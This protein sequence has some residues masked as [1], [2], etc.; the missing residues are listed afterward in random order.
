[1]KM[2]PKIKLPA[3]ED[4]GRSSSN[5]VAT[6]NSHHPLGEIFIYILKNLE[7]NFVYQKKFLENCI[8]MVGIN[9]MKTRFSIPHPK[10]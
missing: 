5:I 3:V 1:M 2:K 10:P 4:I 7:V 9:L 6:Q 8:S